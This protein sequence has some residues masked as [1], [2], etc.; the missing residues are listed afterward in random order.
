MWHNAIASMDPRVRGDDIC[1]KQFIFC[2][3]QSKNTNDE[4]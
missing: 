4:V 1:G 2:H 3:V